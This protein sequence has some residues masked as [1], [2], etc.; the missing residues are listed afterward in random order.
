MDTADE[1]LAMAVSLGADIGNELFQEFESIAQQ[2]RLN[3]P[4]QQQRQSSR[5]RGRG[6]GRGR[7]M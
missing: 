4:T 5:S 1:Q 6:R 7:R 3:Q 2:E